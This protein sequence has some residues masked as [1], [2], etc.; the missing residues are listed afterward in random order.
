VALNAR[1]RDHPS[2]VRPAELQRRPYR[3]FEDNSGHC[4]LTGW[5][6]M[7]VKSNR[8]GEIKPPCAHASPA[9][10]RQRG[11]PRCAITAG[12]HAMA[13]QELLGLAG[14][15]EGLHLPF[16]ASRRPC[17]FSARLLR[18]RLCRVL[19]IR[20]H[21]SLCHAIAPDLIGHDHTRHILQSSELPFEE[22]LRCLRISTGL[23]KYVEHDAVLIHRT[24]EI[25]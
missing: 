23:D 2:A 8:I 19:D 16:S 1:C 22:P 10:T 9:A 15:L 5:R 20:Q 13:E 14:R 6:R 11:G 21:L 17:E 18:W 12:R 3:P 24:P 7:V 4:T 25:I